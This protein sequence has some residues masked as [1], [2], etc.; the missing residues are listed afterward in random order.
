MFDILRLL[1]TSWKKPSAIPEDTDHVLFRSVFFLEKTC[2]KTGIFTFFLSI[3]LC[4]FMD[5]WDFDGFWMLF[6]WLLGWLLLASGIP[7]RVSL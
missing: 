5:F 3:F 2:S 4:F 7:V 6:G 1:E